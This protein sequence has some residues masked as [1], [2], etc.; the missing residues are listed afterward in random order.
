MLPISSSLL[1]SP[2]TFACI[3]DARPLLAGWASS[4]N[5]VHQGIEMVFKSQC[6]AHPPTHLPHPARWER[7]VCEPLPP[8]PHSV[9]HPQR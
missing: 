1:P 6:L 3:S 8:R 5:T 9:V 4:C 7:V 2:C